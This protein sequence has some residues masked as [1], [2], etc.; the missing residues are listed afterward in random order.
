LG[1]LMRLMADAAFAEARNSTADDLEDECRDL[2]GSLL[3]SIESNDERPLRHEMARLLTLTAARAEDAHVWQAAVSA[4]YRTTSALEQLAPGVEPVRILELLDHARLDVSEQAQRQTYRALLEQQDMMSRLGLLTSQ[5]LATVDRSRMAEILAGHLPGLGVGQLVACRYVATDAGTPDDA[6]PDAMSE[7]IMSVGAPGL[8]VGSRFLTRSFPPPALLPVGGVCQLLVLPLRIDGDDRGFVAMT[9]ASLEP[10]AAIVSN[11]ATALRTADL[12]RDALEGRRQAEEASTVKSRFLSMVSHELRTPL[13]VVVGLGDMMLSEAREAAGASGPVIEDLERM[14]AS[15]GHLGRLIDDVLD[16]ASSEAGQLR[17]MVEPLDLAE[18]LSAPIA[19]GRQMASAKGLAFEADIPASGPWVLGDRTR[20]RQIVLNLIGNA[21]KFTESGRVGL[22]VVPAEGEVT[23]TVRDT[24]DGV[25]AGEEARIFTEFHRAARSRPGRIDGLGLGLAIARHL[26][27]LHG[28]S[29]AVRSPGLDGRG[30]TF[31]VTL[32]SVAG[33]LPPVSAAERA[34]PVDAPNRLVEPGEPG[35]PGSLVEPGVRVEPAPVGVGVG[36]DLAASAAGT[37]RQPVVLIVDDDPDTLDL[38]ARI[39]AGAGG[40]AVRASDG[41]EVMSIITRDRPDLVLLDL[42]M[43]GVDGFAVLDALRARASTRDIPVI[44]VT[45]QSVSDQDLGRLH[46]GVAT[47]LRKDVFTTREIA[48]RIHAALSGHHALGGATQLLVRRAVAYIEQHHA[49]PMTRDDIARHVAIS[50]DYLTD[51]FRQELGITPMAYLSRSRIG[52]ARRLL[53]TT[54][55]TITSI[56]MTAGFSEVSHFTR[57]F[58]REVGVS[59]RAYRRGDHRTHPAGAL[60]GLP[61][62][63][64]P[65][66]PDRSPGIGQEHPVGRQDP[67]TPPS[68][69]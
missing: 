48:A 9:A 29:I 4:L 15:A 6:D 14:A 39:V 40:R 42:A 52:H 68:T 16:L 18:V 45:G 38:H 67:R 54:D 44:V 36:R 23:I 57:T 51:C 7:V 5:L 25:P 10:A 61:D 60:T 2:L 62:A 12:Y 46:Q 58:H 19:V 69:E 53:E 13:S 24:G 20:L 30:S 59:P 63:V 37:P 11:L 21:V 47:I 32:P 50:A 3:T 28:G 64:S 41:T 26:V 33:R 8:A 22:D 43:P 65:R 31:T 66:A 56:A 49:E 17:L 34:F 55:E 35:E 1:A 27:E